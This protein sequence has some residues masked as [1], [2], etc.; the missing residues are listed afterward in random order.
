M[1]QV[2]VAQILGLIVPHGRQLL[3]HGEDVAK[4]Q[5]RN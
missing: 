5:R 4:C 2:N 1:R 3:V